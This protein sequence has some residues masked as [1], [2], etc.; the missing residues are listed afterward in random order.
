MT[1]FRWNNKNP[2]SFLNKVFI[3]QASMGAGEVEKNEVG[4][5]HPSAPT[6]QS[7]RSSCSPASDLPKKRK[8]PL[9]VPLIE[10][11][12]LACRNQSYFQPCDFPLFSNNPRSIFSLPLS[13]PW[14][15]RKH[16][17][18]SEDEGLFCFHRNFPLS[19]WTSGTSIEKLL[20]GFSPRDESYDGTTKWKITQPVGHPMIGN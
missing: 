8:W 7:S 2:I 9:A 1:A 17:R 3:S 5:S 6:S 15:Q 14:H 12:H 11:T 18:Q 10:R 20:L 13:Q 19:P 16:H 4:P